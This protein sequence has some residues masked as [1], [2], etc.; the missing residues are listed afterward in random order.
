MKL[1]QVSMTVSRTINLGDYNSLRLEA[2][3]VIEFESG[4]EPDPK[5]ARERMLEEVRTSLREQYVAFKQKK[6]NGT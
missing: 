4:E 2:G 5:A 1:S 6:G 3:A